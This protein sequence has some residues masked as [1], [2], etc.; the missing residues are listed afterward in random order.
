MHRVAYEASKFDDLHVEGA[1]QISESSVK[2]RT[3]D[4]KIYERDINSQ[5]GREW[6]FKSLINY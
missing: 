6:Q 1:L 5:K 3:W 2:L 4:L